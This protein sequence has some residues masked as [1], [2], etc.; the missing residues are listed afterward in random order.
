M[1]EIKG[2]VLNVAD[3]DSSQ[4]IKIAALRMY[5]CCVE[6]INYDDFFDSKSE[7]YISHNARERFRFLAGDYFCFMKTIFV[8]FLSC[9]MLELCFIVTVSSGYRN[10]ETS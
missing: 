4:K 2:T 6:R 8:V 5:T 3:L 10:T 7:S 9:L 1:V